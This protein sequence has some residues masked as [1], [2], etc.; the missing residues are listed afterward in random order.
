MKASVQVAN[1]TWPGGDAAIGS[2]LRTV[3][4]AAEEAGFD[5]LWVMDHF[6]QL[7]PMLGPADN[8]MLEG[9]SALSFLAGITERIRLG[10][11]IM[12]ISRPLVSAL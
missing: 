5:T 11:G 10:T 4:S 7:E 2:S 1:F 3:A 8:A 12:Q 9:Y 6:F